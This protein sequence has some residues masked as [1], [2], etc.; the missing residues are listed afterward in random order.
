MSYLVLIT[1][2]LCG[3]S[4]SLKKIEA[5]QD[6]ALRIL[7]NDSTNDYNQL[8]NKSSKASMEVKHLR[9]LALE[10]FKTLN[11]IW[12]L[13]TWNF[14]FIKLQILHIDIKAN[15]NNT[16]KYGNNTTK[17]GNNTTKYGNKSLRSLGPHIWNFL[18]KQIKKETN[19]NKF[20]ENFID[21]WFGA[22]C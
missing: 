5:I 6:W 20:L 17:Y 10:I 9:K 18:P 19:Y 8:L 4:K 7:Y 21:K 2:L 13:N 22:K 14:F 12:T 3:I 15:Q 11:P 1:V 16:T